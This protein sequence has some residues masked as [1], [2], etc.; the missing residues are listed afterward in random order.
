MFALSPK[1]ASELWG[2]H[3]Y[4]TSVMARYQASAAGAIFVLLGC[5]AV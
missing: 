1:N 3:L 5:N 2:L 4:N